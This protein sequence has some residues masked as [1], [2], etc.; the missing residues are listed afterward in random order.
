[1]EITVIKMEQ[2]K[3]GRP[4]SCVDATDWMHQVTCKVPAC[5][6]FYNRLR[7]VSESEVA[8]ENSK[9]VGA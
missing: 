9:K 4:D 1:M 2:A 6:A 5:F 8:H 7:E 3:R